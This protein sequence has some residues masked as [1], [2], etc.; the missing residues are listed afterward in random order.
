MVLPELGRALGPRGHVRVELG[1][2]GDLCGLGR[3]YQ[4]VHKG[5]IWERD[6]FLKNE[7]ILFCF[8]I[9]NFTR[10]FNIL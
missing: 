10:S 3:D 9:F 8:Q 7:M 1:I 2:V 4:S 6:Y 5:G